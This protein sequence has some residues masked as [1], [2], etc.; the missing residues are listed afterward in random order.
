M[1]YRRMPIEIES[2]EERGYDTIDCNL[3]ESSVR[4]LELQVLGVELSRLPLAY[5]DHRGKRALR[6]ALGES[7]GEGGQT[8]APEQVLLTAGAAS[9]LFIVATSILQPGSHCLIASPNYATNL[10]TPRL[11]GAALECIPLTFETGFCLDLEQL[12]SRMRP[13]TRLI[14]VTYPHNPSGVNLKLK[15]FLTLIEW[16]EQQGCWLLVDET[17]RELTHDQP[18]PMAASL[19]P[20]AISIG[21]FS[22]AYGLPG[23]RIGWLLTQSA[24]LMETFLAAKEQIYVC[25]SILDEELAWAAYAQRERLL[26]PIRAH[27]RE[28]FDTVKC[29]MVQEPLLEWVEPQGGV[30]C[31]PRLRAPER[32]DIPHFY[33]VLEQQHRTYVG[34]GRWFG[35]SDAYFRLGYAWPLLDELKRGLANISSALRE[36][37]RSG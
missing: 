36:A 4:D 30:V 32:V 13:E 11:L 3:T 25:N 24:D 29:W 22:K 23:L 20:R 7:A 2:P 5:T 14:S 10:E 8:L 6:R 26:T 18:L 19:S 35:L 31:F 1:Q 33:Q 27:M 37:Q 16:A 34:P 28:A 9:A 15:D 21:S 17:Y 12:K